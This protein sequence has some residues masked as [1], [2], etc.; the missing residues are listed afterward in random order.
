MSSTSG[1][2]IDGK[3]IPDPFNYVRFLL[4]TGPN[5]TPPRRRAVWKMMQHLRRGGKITDGPWRRLPKI[6]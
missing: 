6:K 4:M 2:E 5:A 3:P 1:L